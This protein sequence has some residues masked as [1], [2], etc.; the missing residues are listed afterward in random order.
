MISTPGPG[1]LSSVPL[2]QELSH[3][4]PW[5]RNSVIS[6]PGPRTLSSVALGQELCL[7][8]PWA[9]NSVIG[10][11]GP[12]T[13]SSV[14]LGQELCLQYPWAKN[15]VFSTTVFLLPT[16]MLYLWTF[17]VIRDGHGQQK[18]QSSGES[19]R[20]LTTVDLRP[21][22]ASVNFWDAKCGLRCCGNGTY[23]FR[24]ASQRGPSRSVYIQLQRQVTHV[25]FKI[26]RG[27]S[28]VHSVDL[29]GWRRKGKGEQDPEGGIGGERD[30]PGVALLVAEG[31]IRVVLGLADSPCGC[32]V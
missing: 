8:Y 31:I 2:G 11:P 3:Q 14:P 23:S 21:R 32:G 18:I 27:L 25:E 13:L 26:G 6:T 22:E 15:S 19:W 10:T 29:E 17:F 24:A 9:R 20:V 12:G 16:S 7:Q 30:P 1:T 4:Y 5:A 28:S